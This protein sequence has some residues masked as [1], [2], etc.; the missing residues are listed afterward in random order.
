MKPDGWLFR[1]RLF[2]QRFWQPTT[3][4]LTCMP[5]SVA[6]FASLPHWQI[7]LQTGLVTGVLVLALSFTPLARVFRH[8]YQNAVVVGCLTAL[9]DAWAHADNYGTVYAEAI[10]TGVVSGLL[11]LVMSFA[12][13]DRARRVRAAWTRMR[14]RAP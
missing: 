9:G 10:V 4:C 5:G 11:A 7:A 13:E 14:G 8:R 1:A 3:A 12:L 2:A 6:N